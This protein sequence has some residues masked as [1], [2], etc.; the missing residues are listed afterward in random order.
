[1]SFLTISLNSGKD[2]Y[3]VDLDG[4]GDKPWKKAGADITDY[5]NF[6]FNEASWKEYADKQNMIRSGQQGQMDNMQQMMMM[7]GFPMMAQMN[8]NQPSQA[9]ST[10]RKR[11]SRPLDE[12]II[13]LSSKV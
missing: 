7:A 10:K 11:A 9:T 8:G 3:D 6:G 4:F 2:I 1:V 12:C 5:F 13:D